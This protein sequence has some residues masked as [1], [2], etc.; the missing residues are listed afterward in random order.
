MWALAVLVGKKTCFSKFRIKKKKKKKLDLDFRSRFY[1]LDHRS[2]LDLYKIGYVLTFR[3]LD[4][5]V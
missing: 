4:L 1:R 2:S 3:G 5:I